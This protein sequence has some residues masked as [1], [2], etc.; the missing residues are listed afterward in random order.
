MSE[1]GPG[2]GFGFFL[3]L[4]CVAPAILLDSDPW[5]QIAIGNAIA[6]FITGFAWTMA[7][8]R[9]GPMPS[10]YAK[11]LGIGIWSVTHLIALALLV[12]AIFVD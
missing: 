11:Q 1:S 6:H 7:G 10:F 4:I 8:T 3:L 2:L 5:K 12:A 9:S